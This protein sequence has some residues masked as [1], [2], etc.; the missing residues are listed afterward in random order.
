MAA[1]T[2]NM[3][4][5]EIFLTITDHKLIFVNYKSVSVMTEAVSFLLQ[6]KLICLAVLSSNYFL[7]GFNATRFQ[8]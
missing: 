6:P 7:Y 3:I 4:F 2:S 1:K 5:R 8:I